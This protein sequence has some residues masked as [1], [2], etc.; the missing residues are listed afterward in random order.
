MISILDD[1]VVWDFKISEISEKSRDFG[2]T[3]RRGFED[4]FWCYLN[5]KDL[6]FQNLRNLRKVPRR[7]FEDC[8]LSAI[9]LDIGIKI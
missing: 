7:G 9:F 1:N 3:P 6:E 8:S 5:L 2:N 4:T